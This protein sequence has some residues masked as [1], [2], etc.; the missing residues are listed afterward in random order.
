M[1]EKQRLKKEGIIPGDNDPDVDCG[2]N[3]EVDGE[4]DPRV[5]NDLFDS[6]DPVGV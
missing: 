6:D 3:D 4:V 2:V 5:D 1:K